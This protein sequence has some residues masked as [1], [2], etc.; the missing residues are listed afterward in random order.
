MNLKQTL[1]GAFVATSLVTLPMALTTVPAMAKVTK[2]TSTTKTTSTGSAVTIKNGTTVNGKLDTTLDSGKNTDGDTFAMVIKPGLFQDK[3]L[4]GAIL[5][6]HVEGVKSAAK[7]GKKGELDIVFDDIKTTD[8][9]VVPITAMLASA[10][11]PEGKMLR[12]M[13][14]VLGGAVVGHHV[15]KA[16]GKKHGSLMGA[17]A[18]GAV[19]IAMPGGNVVIK[20]GTELKVKFTQDVAI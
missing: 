6:G 14:L 11:K 12:N 20:S 15:G 13:A 5:E 1:M 2:M 19:A 9:K 16:T 3:T 18:G 8:G 4:K 17:V 10:P 7:F